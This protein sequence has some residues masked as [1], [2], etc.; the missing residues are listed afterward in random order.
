MM[1]LTTECLV[2]MKR[3]FKRFV[4]L[5]MFVVLNIW[6]VGVYCQWGRQNWVSWRLGLPL[7]L[8]GVLDGYPYPEEDLLFSLGNVWVTGRKDGRRSFCSLASKNSV[9]FSV[10]RAGQGENPDGTSYKCTL[11]TT[12]C[13]LA[14]HASSNGLCQKV[15]FR[16]NDGPAFR[17]L[18]GDGSI[19]RIE[20]KVNYL[21]S[22]DSVGNRRRDG[23]FTFDPHIIYLLNS[24]E[25][26]Q[27][28]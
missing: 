12:N 24:I 10:D 14:W 23:D 7:R 16:Y 9:M 22:V 8:D 13:F 4:L 1:R 21:S 3:R 2:L 27:D 11:M 19:E 20:R 6:S 28:L 5:P 26:L 17:D 18:R 25:E 15:A